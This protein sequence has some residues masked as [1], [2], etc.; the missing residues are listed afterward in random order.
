[1]H[2]NID[3]TAHVQQNCTL[4]PWTEVGKRTK[5]D[6]TIMGDYSYICNDGDVIYTTIGKFCSIAS[7]VR[8]NPGNHP[9]QRA[10]LH[11]FT[12]RSKQF[13]LGED[14]PAFFDWR[15]ASHVRI[16]NDVWIGHGATVMPGVTIGDGAVIGSGA[17]VTKDVA[18]F[19]IVAGVPAKVLRKR[20]SDETCQKLASLKWWDWPH[21]ILKERMPSFRELEAEAFADLYLQST[22]CEF[23]DN[24]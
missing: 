15:R 21:D 10:A 11:H 7:H 8:I 22:N 12:Y 24:T 1:M 3:P 13:D 6:E 5:L 2:P 23:V 18:P 4:G 19:T 16:G 14:D 17:V 9:L 20:F